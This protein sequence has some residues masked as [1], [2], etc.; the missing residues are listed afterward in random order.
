[1]VQACLSINVFAKE[2]V[3]YKVIF[4]SE[5]SGDRTLGIRVADEWKLSTIKSR[6]VH[7]VKVEIV[8]T[9]PELIF[10]CSDLNLHL[11]HNAHIRQQSYA[12][13]S[14]LLPPGNRRTS[15]TSPLRSLSIFS[16]TSLLSASQSRSAHTS[17]VAPRFACRS[18][19]S[20]PSIPAC[21]FTYTNL[22]FCF[23]KAR[24]SRSDARYWR[25]GAF[26]TGVPS[27]LVKLLCSQL[28]NHFVRPGV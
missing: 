9:V 6:K 22:T 20:F 28:G 15:L 10:I 14:I 1:M 24:S 21:P 12:R 3:S 25:R 17:I 23:R 26:C 7:F 13:T 18:A 27:R 19:P 11:E 8:Y 16:L 4:C 2:K 5:V